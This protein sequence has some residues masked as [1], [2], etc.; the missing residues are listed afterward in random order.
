MQDVSE[1]IDVSEIR[2]Q[3]TRRPRGRGHSQTLEEWQRGQVPAANRNS[4]R[5]KVFH[6][7]GRRPAFERKREH[8]DAIGGSPRTQ[9]PQATHLAEPE[10][11]VW[12]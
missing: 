6:D 10:I 11:P 12:V 8:G 3:V 7:L 1:A 5:V 2:V 4:G 9:N